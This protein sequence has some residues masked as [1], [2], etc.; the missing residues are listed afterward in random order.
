MNFINFAVKRYVAIFC[1]MIAITGLG[2]N[3][4]RKLPLEE[5]PRTDM[6]FITVVTI[7]PGASPGEIE[8]DVAKPVEDAL[9]ALD[10]LKS[11]RS[12]CMENV[13]QTFLEFNVG[14]NVDI[15]ANDVRDKLDFIISNFP[16]GVERPRVLKFDINAQPVVNIALTG[17]LPIEELFDY[18]D[19]EFRDRLATVNGV[20]DIILT[21]GARREVQV[22]LDRNKLAARGLNSLDVVVALRR[23]MKMIPVGR[24]RQNGIEHA[25]KFDA[26]VNRISDIEQIE[27]L[28]SNG[29]RC[30]V[31]DVGRV[32]MGSVEQRQQAMING[33]PGIAARIIKK[34]D[35]NAVEVVRRV[36]KEI[37]AMR[38][39]AP[40]GIELVWV[41]DAGNFIRASVDSAVSNIWQG[42]LLTAILLFFFLYDIKSTL[43]VALSMPVTVIAGVWLISTLDYSLNTSTLLA[44][45]LS[46]GILITNSIVVLE[47]I[48]SCRKSSADIKDAAAKGSEKVLPAVLASAATNVVV[49][50]PVSLMKGQIGQFFIPFALTMVLRI[51]SERITLWCFLTRL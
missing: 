5:L 37:I 26:E 48:V 22:L 19:N 42:I 12:A 49:L 11:I 10:G 24:I 44:L 6:P 18:A 34:S 9:G 47:S 21:G 3:S 46:I 51:Q 1:L 50:F 43:I 27:L 29:I 17:S 8:T 40:G 30:Y 25:I 15:S 39:E 36:E 31:R 38:N 7:Y 32:I 45:G 14:T 23:E 16:E 20:A 2:I 4:Y 35:A 33:R 41:S 28:N 13:C